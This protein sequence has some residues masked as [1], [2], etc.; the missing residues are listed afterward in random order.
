MSLKTLQDK[1]I[2]RMGAVKPIVKEKVLDII[3]QAYNEG[4]YVLITDGYRSYAEQDALYA[5]GRTKPGK[6]V[7]NAK[8]GQSNH[9]FGIAVDFCLT[10]KEG[11]AAY[12]TVNAQWKRV[13][14]IAKSMGFEW[15]GDWTSFKDNPHLEYTGKITVT[16]DTKVD[17]EVVTTPSKP[18]GGNSNIKA[19][20]KFLNGYASKAKFT[21]LNEDG[22]T[23]PKTKTAY[24]RVYQHLV[25]V[26]VDGIF[27]PKSKAAAPIVQKGKSSATWNKFVQGLLYCH[28]YDPRG[29]DG[30]FG[31]GMLA[32]VKKFQKDKGLT[33]D[34][35]VGPNT[36]AKFFA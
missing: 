9:N 16:P 1:A 18:S 33:V 21:K 24:I 23:G 20:Q 25:G 10:N 7:T 2:K 5:Q 22:Y 8:G 35:I 13:A 6:I 32:S 4:I 29:F 17:S 11:T 36:F 31:N 14:A 19:Y 26:A 28:G 27:G 15:G 12:W 30:I 3:E 34:G